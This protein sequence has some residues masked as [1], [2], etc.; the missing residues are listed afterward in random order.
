MSE[1]LKKKTRYLQPMYVFSIH[2]DPIHYLLINKTNNYVLSNDFSGKVIYWDLI[3]QKFIWETNNSIGASTAFA[4]FHDGRKFI[5]AIIFPKDIKRKDCVIGE[6]QDDSCLNIRD[7]ESGVIINSIK[8]SKVYISS[9]NITPDD[10]FVILGFNNGD[11]TKVDLRKGEIIYSIQ[12]HKS[13]IYQ[14]EIIHEGTQFLTGSQ[15]SS[16]KQWDIETGELLANFEDNEGDVYHFSLTPDE[17]YFIS[18]SNS[19]SLSLWNLQTKNKIQMV[20]F[21]KSTMYAVQFSPDGTFFFSGCGD[22]LMLWDF[23]DHQMSILE[24]IE[25]DRVM[26]LS[27]SNDGQY[28]VQSGKTLQVWKIESIDT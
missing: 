9:M 1:N 3:T 17:Y 4:I 16:V 13:E 6:Y 14:I 18:A 2:H 5:D 7:L 10:N 21:Q 20:E 23:T 12:G 11:I 8:L 27:F 19:G 24:Q 28:L 26:S 25:T 15:D 22:A